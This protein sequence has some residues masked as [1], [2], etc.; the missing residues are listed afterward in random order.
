MSYRLLEL[1]NMVIAHLDVSKTQCVLIFDDASIIKVMEAAQQRTS[2]RQSGSIIVNGNF[3]N[4]LDDLNV[5]YP[6]KIR[7]GE[8]QDNVFVYYNTI[9]LPCHVYGDVA[10]RMH[11][12]GIEQPLEINGEE[13]EVVLDGNPKYV[14]HID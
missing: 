8:F 5:E 11:Y 1:P 9:R 7:S 2:W 4:Y 10:I 13:I 14:A 6:I 12:P 3:D